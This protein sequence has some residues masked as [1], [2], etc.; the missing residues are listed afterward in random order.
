M[1]AQAICRHAI[2]SAQSGLDAPLEAKRISEA[3]KQWGE[4]VESLRVHIALHPRMPGSA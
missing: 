1:E 2:V 3:Y 4:A